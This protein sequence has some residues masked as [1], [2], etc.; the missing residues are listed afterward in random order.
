MAVV[1][2]SQFDLMRLKSTA[3]GAAESLPDSVG[4]SD[5]S[6]SVPPVCEGALAKQFATLRGVNAFATAC[7]V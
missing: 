4:I 5:S 2:V 3:G 1:R 7:K 6:L